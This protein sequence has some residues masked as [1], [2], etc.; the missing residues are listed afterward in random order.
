MK[1]RERMSDEIA[2]YHT[3]INISIRIYMKLTRKAIIHNHRKT[4]TTPKQSNSIKHTLTQTDKIHTQPNKHTHTKSIATKHRRTQHK[5]SIR[6]T[7][8]NTSNT[9]EQASAR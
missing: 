1:R 9:Q 8:E 7:C 6:T 2:Q 5:N 4:H 3:R